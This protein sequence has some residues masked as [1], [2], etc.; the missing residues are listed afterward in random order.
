[1]WFWSKTEKENSFSG[2]KNAQTANWAEPTISLARA[3]RPAA[4]SPS[5]RA[6]SLPC[7]PSMAVAHFC[8]FPSSM[9]RTRV[10]LQLDQIHPNLARSVPI[11]SAYLIPQPPPP[12]TPNQSHLRA[13][14]LL[15]LVLNVPPLPPPWSSNSGEHRQLQALPPIPSSSFWS[16]APLWLDPVFFRAWNRADRDRPDA[17]A[18][19]PTPVN[20]PGRSKTPATTPS[21][22]ST[23]P[24][25][26]EHRGMLH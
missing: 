8:S 24:R 18:V 11:P 5:R 20:D 15:E 23:P 14:R 19:S 7:G 22:T 10:D 26:P 6:L 21:S 12:K 3:Q 16:R 2:K 17:A 13:A 25:R 1:M 4:H 9:G